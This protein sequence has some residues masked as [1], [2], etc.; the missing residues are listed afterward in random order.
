M[1]TELLTR[2]LCSLAES[3]DVPGEVGGLVLGGQHLGAVG[4]PGL[5]GQ[6]AGLLQQEAGDTEGRQSGR[7]SIQWVSPQQRETKINCWN[8]CVGS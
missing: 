5:S 2:S 6:A 4:E 8:C 1:V 7:V 3:R